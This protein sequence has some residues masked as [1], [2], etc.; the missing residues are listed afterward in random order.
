MK[1]F[2]FGRMH[3]PNV[4]DVSFPNNVDKDVQAMLF[5]LNLMQN[6]LLCPKYRIKNNI[7]SPNS[8]ISNVIS[9]IATIGYIILFRLRNYLVQNYYIDG[10]G[11]LT[12]NLYFDICFYIIGFVIVQWWT[13]GSLIMK[14]SVSSQYRFNNLNS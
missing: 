8:V 6:V 10:S 14:T 7:I 13:F 1:F 5:P 4:V 2:N 11:G 9:L 3:Q 12:A